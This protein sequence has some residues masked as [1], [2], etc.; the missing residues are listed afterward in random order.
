MEESDRSIL[1]VSRC[2]RASLPRGRW[3]GGFA[4]IVVFAC[5]GG[6]RAIGQEPPPAPPRGAGGAE[7]GSARRTVPDAL[8]F[9]NGLL[10]E[11]RYEL[12]A[13]EY[14]RFIKSGPQGRDLDDA[15]YGLGNAR[16]NQGKYEDA[17]RAFT[18]FIKGAPQD[19]RKL[20]ARYRLGELAYLAGD[21][22]GARRLLEEYI[23]ATTDHPGLEMA[24]VYLGDACFGLQDFPAARL[25]YEQS[26]AAHP[27]GRLADRA[28]YGLGRA[29]GAVGER[30]KAI[31]VL[32][33]LIRGSKPE[34]VDRAW[35]QIGLVKKGAGQLAEAAEAF[36][37]V[38]KAAPRS[39]LISEARIQRALTLVRLGRDSEAEPLFRALVNDPSASTGARAAL[40][41]GTLELERKE[42]EAAM[43]TLET[44]L[45]RYPGSSVAP[46]IG[47]RIAE[48]L[49][50]QGKL[51]EAQAKFEKLVAANPDDPWADDAT[52]RAAQAAFDRGDLNDARRLAA[53]FASHY[54]TSP[55]RAEVLLI[56]AR[57]AA[58]LGK[59]DEAA[60]ILKGL[61]ASTDA[62]AKDAAPKTPAP[63]LETARYELA[64]AY[65]A[66]GN[67]ALADDL[68]N[69]LANEGTGPIAVNARFLIGQSHLDNGRYREAIQPLE[70]YLSSNP[71]G[72]VAAIAMAHLVSARLALGEDAE[73][74][75]VLATLAERFPGSKA[76]ATTRLRLAEKALADHKAEQAALQF[77]LAAD[78]IADTRGAGSGSGAKSN[79]SSDRQLQARALTGLGRSLSE[80]GKP[81]EAAAAF[82]KVLELA[83]DATSAPEVAVA[84]ARA[85]EA[86][87]QDDAAL[88]AYAVIEKRFPNSEHA[89][90]AALS[91]ARLFTKKGQ[92]D[93]AAEAFRRLLTDEHAA[94][95]LTGLGVPLDMLLSEYASVLLDD[96]KVAE[97]DQVFSR[98]L[99]DFPES[100]YSAEA[101][102]NLAESANTARNFAEVVR[103][104]T[105]LASL[106]PDDSSR[107]AKK[108]AVGQGPGQSTESGAEVV[109]RVLP[110]SLYRL[111]RTQFEL[112]E[113]SAAVTT[114]DRLLGE[115]P[116]NPFRREAEYLR[117]E[118]AWQLNDFVAA[119]K[120]FSALLAEP[121]AASDPKEMVKAVKQKQ[122]KCWVALKRW[123]DVLDAV[124]TEKDRVSPGDRSIAELDFLRGQALMGLGQIAD[125]RAAFQAVID[126]RKE[127]D[128]V[129]QSLLMRGETY[130]H[131]DQ[132][133]EALRDFLRVDILHESPRWQA[134]A[135][136]EAGKVY[137]RLDQW[138]D[139]AETYERLLKKFPS[140]PTAA[141]ARERL[142]AASRRAAANGGTKKS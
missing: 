42:L 130:F 32:D 114:L 28:K 89:A 105:P 6:E 111:G 56:D 122:I 9:A 131:Q 57:A 44:G 65:R 37:T 24:R 125:A 60:V 25:A 103:L 21:L 101:R 17:R 50:R 46:A 74:W 120:R 138:A 98:L 77:R 20:T 45:K 91:Q 47:F 10:R 63:L 93:R 86:N 54:P 117:A 26:L 15:R 113:W 2:E 119:E 107:P 19:S 8:R 127:G 40:E 11:R 84:Q 132:F 90:V 29:L 72:D 64:L 62:K 106:K 55:L 52:E 129:A 76:L 82:S 94:N 124:Q 33:D 59:H 23:A 49:E 36:A 118:T 83:P 115:F 35:L 66:A 141:T 18:E 58:R 108:D 34:W 133:H 5:V 12:A 69:R 43:R 14:E 13:D 92:R 116:D 88:A 134:A 51:L 38:E 53:A 128:L 1:A 30:D 71:R 102:F 68:L 135:L 3:F 123:K 70:S 39:P 85:L 81:A 4:L 96:G 140:E 80:L 73:A 75:K 31:S 97:A 110:A 137:E 79:D 41:L 22:S 67:V 78:L 126:G 142:G 139:A 112:K 100:P 99:K 109:R 136:L 95:K 87:Q 27:S 121:P 48:V 104:L 7:T 16:L 61:I